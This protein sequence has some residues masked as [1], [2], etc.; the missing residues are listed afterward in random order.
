MLQAECTT[1]HFPV[2][3]RDFSSTK[4]PDGCGAQTGHSWI[5]VK[6]WAVWLFPWG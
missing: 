6:L 2:G 5:P 4:C 1:A 3:K